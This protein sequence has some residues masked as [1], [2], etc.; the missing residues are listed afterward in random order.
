MH[1]ERHFSCP[2]QFLKA[3]RLAPSRPP[4][5]ITSSSEKHTIRAHSSPNEPRGKTTPK[6]KHRALPNTLNRFQKH[7]ADIAMA[8]VS[9]KQLVLKWAKFPPTFITGDKSGRVP[10][11][12]MHQVDGRGQQLLDPLSLLNHSPRV[13]T[14]THLPPLKCPL[15]RLRN[16]INRTRSHF[17]SHRIPLITTRMPLKAPWNQMLQRRRTTPWALI[18]GHVHRPLRVKT[19]STR[20]A[21]PAARGHQSAIRLHS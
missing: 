3:I 21:N 11:F 4:T 20:A 2:L 6:W 7:T 1:F 18:V 17:R 9:H 12:A 5:A 15:K 14:R 13:A 19:Q 10:D 16:G 8:L